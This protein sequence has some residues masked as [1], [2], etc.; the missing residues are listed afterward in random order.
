MKASGPT[1]SAMASD[2]SGLAMAMS[3]RA[4]IM[5]GKFTVRESTYGLAARCSMGSG[6]RD[7][8]KA[9]VFGKGLRAIA[10]LVSGS[11]TNQTASE[12]TFGVT[13]TSTK[14]NGN[15]A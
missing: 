13:E 15:N 5:M 1:T 7:R 2:M 10:I 8:K 11:Q 12:S 3:T 6:F 14:A 4:N 9:M